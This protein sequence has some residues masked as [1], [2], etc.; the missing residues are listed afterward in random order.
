[1]VFKKNSLVLT[2][3]FLI[4]CFLCACGNKD[5]VTGESLSESTEEVSVIEKA[6][7][8]EKEAAKQWEKG[9]DLPVDELEMIVDKSMWPMPSYGDLIFEV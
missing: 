9:Y 2:M 7:T 1:M 3:V 5:S 6:K 4:G 8:G